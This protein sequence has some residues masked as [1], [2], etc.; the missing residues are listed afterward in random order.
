MPS[1]RHGLLA[2]SLVLASLGCPPDNKDLLYEPVPLEAHDVKI[3]ADAQGDA[4]TPAHVAVFMK[5]GV[6]Q[7]KGGAAHTLEGVATGA[8]GDAPPRLEL[9]QDRVALTQSTLG[10][11]AP[12]GDAKF[13]LALGATPMALEIETG[14]GEAQTIDLGGVALAQARFHTEAGHLSIDWSAPNRL[15]GAKLKLVTE[16]G[17]ID[18]THLG[19][20]GATSIEVTSIAGVVSLDMSDLAADATP[21]AVLAITAKV[22]SGKLVFTVPK[23]LAARATFDVSAGDIVSKGWTPGD[24]AG[25]FVVGDPKASPR[26]V[27]RV[28]ALAGQVEL[29]AE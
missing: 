11:N 2:A 23:A 4:K 24:S 9:M 21:S 18:V 6:L 14:K 8:V 1:R 29:R 27:A 17:Y 22:T 26:I 16:A 15:P 7:M 20:S 13:M 10:G 25:T 19:K 3:V 28:T 5:R 12:R